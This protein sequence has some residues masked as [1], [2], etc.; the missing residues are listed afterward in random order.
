MVRLGARWTLLGC[1]QSK[2]FWAQRIDARFGRVQKP[3][4]HLV[5]F[6]DD[7]VSYHDHVSA[8]MDYK[9]GALRDVFEKFA[10]LGRGL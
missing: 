8:I 3:R 10:R 4:G 2:G 6:C 9:D 7:D 5:R 1:G